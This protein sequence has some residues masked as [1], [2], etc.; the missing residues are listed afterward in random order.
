MPAFQRVGAVCWKELSDI[1]RVD[2][3]GRSSERQSD[4]LEELCGYIYNRVDNRGLKYLL[5]K[6]YDLVVDSNNICF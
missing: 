3:C 2:M 6:R 1:L 5:S 4:E